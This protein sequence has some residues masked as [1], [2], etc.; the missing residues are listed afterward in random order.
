[1]GLTGVG[2][3]RIAR[4]AGG[5]GRVGVLTL[6]G[7]GKVERNRRI[8]GVRGL[9]RIARIEG[10]GGVEANGGI[11]RVRGVGGGVGP[12]NGVREVGGVNGA[13]RG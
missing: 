13:E 9:W 1:M 6:G 4:G 10:V 2:G 11:G 7:V 8:G 12:G 3:V 5:F